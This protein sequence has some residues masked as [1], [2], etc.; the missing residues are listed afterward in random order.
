MSEW[1]IIPSQVH[2]AA[3]VM[4]DRVGQLE[5]A[6]A[7]IEGTTFPTG[8]GFQTSAALNSLARFWGGQVRAGATQI[9]NVADAVHDSASLMSSAEAD[10][11]AAGEA[12][13][14][15]IESL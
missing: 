4:D 8:D 3:G 9:S 2:A 1:W 7:G 14:T 15:R 6:A 11:A 13:R 5:Q 12:L 10:A